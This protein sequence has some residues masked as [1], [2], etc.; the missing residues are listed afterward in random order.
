MTTTNLDDA[1]P[2]TPNARREALI[3]TAAA[4]GAFGI[5]GFAPIYFN[6]V[7]AADPLEVLAHRIVWTV[8]LM[9]GLL[10]LPGP[11]R[12][13][14]VL[15]ASRR[16][17][18]YLLTTVLISG[19][20]LLFIWAVTNQ[21]ILE[22]SLGYYIN[23]LVNVVLGV[24]FLSESLNRRQL[25]AVLLAA[26][27]CANLVVSYGALPWVSLT[28][29]VS[30]GLYALV[31]KKAAID[32][33]V[34]LFVETALLAPLA[35]VYL[36]WLGHVGQGQFGGGWTMTLLLIAAG[37]VTGVP[38]VLFM[39]GAQRLRLST[40]GLLQ[41][42]A[43]TLQFLVAV[44]LYREPFTTAHM[45]TFACIWAGLALYSSDAAR[46]RS[47]QPLQAAPGC[48]TADEVSGCRTR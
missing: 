2:L 19:N 35:L 3:G 42:L 40:I 45:I 14:G 27:G 47:R 36:L 32:P 39:Y 15:L 9:A 17:H 1:S 5:W 20:W 29:A 28:L 25:A 43:P 37:A 10:L 4:L 13:L 46:K 44:L 6:L 26:V 8:L 34:G 23:P 22:V 48:G 18:V 33:V 24:V 11:R 38:L 12:A 7:K 41:Y 30:F 16:W 21:R 31:R